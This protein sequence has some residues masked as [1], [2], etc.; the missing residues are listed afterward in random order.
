LSD[1]LARTH[2][3]PSFMATR[4]FG[5][6]S[7]GLVLVTAVVTVLALFFD[8]NAIASIGS[9]VALAVF[10]MVTL[11]H[12][13]IRKETGA[14]LSLLLLALITS[15]VA[16]VTFIFTTLI[17][18]PASIISIGA[19]IGLSI[20]FDVLWSRPSPPEAISAPA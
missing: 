15:A 11:G 14:R 9:A 1:E 16:L 19:I 3:F 13:R 10:G 18:E 8:L 4:L 20:I 5:R 6:A 2:Q 7:V 17:S 12:L